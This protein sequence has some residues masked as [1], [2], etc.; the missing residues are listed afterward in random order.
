MI[1]WVLGSQSAHGFQGSVV[2]L[3]GPAVR[4]AAPGRKKDNPYPNHD[5]RREHRRAHASERTYPHSGSCS[6]YRRIFL[7][8][9]G[10]A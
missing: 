7:W 1:G 2:G 3:D 4:Q 9:A 5:D 10:V 8:S 6:R